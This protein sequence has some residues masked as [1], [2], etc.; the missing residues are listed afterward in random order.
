MISF[1][2]WNTPVKQILLISN[3]QTRTWRLGDLLQPRSHSEQKAGLARIPPESRGGPV[4]TWPLV[5]SPGKDPPPA[6]L[7]WHHHL[8]L[9]LGDYFRALHLGMAVQWSGK[10]LDFGDRGMVLAPTGRGQGT[11]EL[12]RWFHVY[13]HLGGWVIF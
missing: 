8:R 12:D 5:C 9:Q 13:G 7:P 1:N 10:D 4:A 6:S 11:Q 3:L 2:Y